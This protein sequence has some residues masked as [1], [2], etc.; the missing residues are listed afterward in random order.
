MNLWINF[1]YG[2][3]K[4]NNFQDSL[5]RININNIYICLNKGFVNE[6]Y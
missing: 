6:R 2:I 1:T 4:N 5:F 3:K